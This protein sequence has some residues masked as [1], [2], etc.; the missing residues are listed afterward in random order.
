MLGSPSCG[1]IENHDSIPTVGSVAMAQRWGMIRRWFIGRPRKRHQRVTEKVG[2][3][4]PVKG[5]QV[6][7]MG[8]KGICMVQDLDFRQLG[9][10]F[11]ELWYL[12]ADLRG[13]LFQTLLYPT[14]VCRSSTCH[15][16]PMQWAA[17]CVRGQEAVY[18]NSGGPKLCSEEGLAMQACAGGNGIANNLSRDCWR[19]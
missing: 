15:Q 11:L 9:V 10:S 14:L 1:R 12:G 7:S 16:L 6:P 19:T 4:I 8:C 3:A 13:N 18:Q 5:I 17:G 2:I